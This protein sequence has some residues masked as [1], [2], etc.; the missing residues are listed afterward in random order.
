MP[1]LVRADAASTLVPVRIVA[2][3]PPEPKA[4]NATSTPSW[5]PEIA[6]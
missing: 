3:V 1:G 6:V 4:T 5:K 2:D